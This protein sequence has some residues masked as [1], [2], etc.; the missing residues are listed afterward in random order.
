MASTTQH[1]P[2]L[3]DAAAVTT[4]TP[5]SPDATT[6]KRKRRKSRQAIIEEEL[7]QLRLRTF[8]KSES[9]RLNTSLSPRSQLTFDES[10]GD[11]E[12]GTSLKNRQWRR[13]NKRHNGNN[14]IEKMREAA[15]NARVFQLR[16]AGRRSWWPASSGPTV[17]AIPLSSS[18]ITVCARQ[19]DNR[20][21]LKCCND[22]RET[23]KQKKKHEKDKRELVVLTNSIDKLLLEGD[24]MNRNQIM[25]MT[26]KRHRQDGTT[27]ATNK[28]NKFEWKFW[29]KIGKANDID[30]T[31]S[32]DGDTVQSSITNTANNKNNNTNSANNNKDNIL[33]DDDDSAIME[34]AEKIDTEEK[35][36]KQKIVAAVA[37]TSVSSLGVALA[38]I[39]L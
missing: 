14:F 33:L 35:K 27:N 7:W 12:G 39:L 37:T 28:K 16:I 21:V 17:S 15:C 23:W 25:S 18:T 24:S 9:L 34:I 26:E 38:I 20:G 13:S 5:S 10:D 11:G 2:R 29:K 22:D 4:I 3:Q 36:M 30:E 19:N 6:V 32:I 31:T 1:S 8:V